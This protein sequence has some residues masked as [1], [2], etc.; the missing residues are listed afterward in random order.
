[1][2][3]F[4]W[5]GCSGVVAQGGTSISWLLVVLSWFS[6]AVCPGNGVGG[7]NGVV[8]WWVVWARCWVLRERATIVLFCFVSDVAALT[9]D[10][11]CGGRTSGIGPRS[12]LTCVLWVVV[13]HEWLVLPVA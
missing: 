2:L 7:W 3:P 4:R 6:T 10:R 11:W 5:C 1:V 12:Y 8:V 9:G 13:S